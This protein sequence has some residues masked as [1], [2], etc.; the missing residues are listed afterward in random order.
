MKYYEDF[1]APMLDL[2]SNLSIKYV[3]FIF[4]IINQKWGGYP[5]R[6]PGTQKDPGN[7]RIRNS[8][9][10]PENP[11]TKWEF[12]QMG[13]LTT[14]RPSW[15]KWDCCSGCLLD[16]CF[17]HTHTNSLFAPTHFNST[18]VFQTC[19]CNVAVPV[20]PQNQTNK[21]VWKPGCMGI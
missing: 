16:S 12:E 14:F 7:G 21:C 18:F 3:L 1:V 4:F 15:A 8:Q 17:T 13:F 2:D 19:T 6:W 5:L 11:S 10:C 20:F 9:K